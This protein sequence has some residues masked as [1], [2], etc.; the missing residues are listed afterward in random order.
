[1]TTTYHGIFLLIP[2]IRKIVSAPT[3]RVELF[4]E[5]GIR[6]VDAQFLRSLPALALLQITR[7][8]DLGAE[9]LPNVGG[10]DIVGNVGAHSGVAEFQLERCTEESVKQY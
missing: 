10:A 5:L 9:C 7:L 1:M 2:S 6:E 3:L 4:T 8:V